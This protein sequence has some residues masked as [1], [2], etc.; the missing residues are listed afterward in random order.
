MLQFGAPSDR[1]QFIQGASGSVYWFAGLGDQAP[2]RTIEGTPLNDTWTVKTDSEGKFLEVYEEIVEIQEL[3]VDGDAGRYRLKIDSNETRYLSDDASGAAVQ[4]AIRELPGLGTITV[5]SVEGVS[6]RY[7]HT[8][9][10]DG[11]PGDRFSISFVDQTGA[12]YD[13][14]TLRDGDSRLAYASLIDTHPVQ[15]LSMNGYGGSDH[16]ILDLSEGRPIE[17]VSFIGGSGR[18]SLSVID[19][20]EGNEYRFS[21]SRIDR[22]DTGGEMTISYDTVDLI[23]VDGESGAD[24]FRVDSTSVA[25]DLEGGLDADE[26][27]I[28][29]DGQQHDILAPIVASGGNSSDIF[30]VSNTDSSVTLDGGRGTLNTYNVGNG[31]YL[32]NIRGAVSIVEESSVTS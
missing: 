25:L 14:S 8:V 29:T 12:G 3:K 30:E 15:E 16:L 18:D 19:D 31:D 27:Y 10:F 24:I 4:A 21:Q 28:G 23:R 26:F 1:N 32:Q 7:T 2:L 9:Y 17:H 5:R 20:R 11:V 22:L 6:P 13:T